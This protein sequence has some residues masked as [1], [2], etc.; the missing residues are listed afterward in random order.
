[1][2]ARRAML[3]VGLALWGCDDGA[4]EDAVKDA[5]LVVPPDAEGVPQVDARP[6]PPDAAPLPPFP[7]GRPP[8]PPPPDAG[9]P[10]AAP[11]CPAEPEVEAGVWRRPFDSPERAESGDPHHSAREPVVN[12]GA[13]FT[14]DGKFAY[15]LTSWDLEGERVHAFMRVDG[16]WQAVGV[17]NTDTDGRVSIRV[18]LPLPVG[19]YDFRLIVPG[20]MSAAIGAVWVVAPDTPSVVFDVD[21]TLTIGDSELFQEIL[22]GEHP[23]MFEAADRAV[24][25]YA[26]QGYQIIYMTGRPYFLNPATRRWLVAEGFPKGPLR[27]TDSVSQ[28]LPTEE[29]VQAYKRAYVES[30]IADAGLRFAAAY[31]NA[32]T[33]VCGYAQAGIDPGV[34]WIIGENGGSACVGFDA[35][36]DTIDYPTHL[37]QVLVDLPPAR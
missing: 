13:P 16:C 1:V 20:D 7:D 15:G 28:T 14:L 2:T 18:D 9:P 24:Q 30:L 6:P 27:T 31:G 11:P 12:P 34:T 25:R 3:W 4:A 32:H 19:A 8:L 23:E 36:H 29:G 5:A 35:T 17:Q 26:D 33:D 21:G 22:L 37:E 10:D